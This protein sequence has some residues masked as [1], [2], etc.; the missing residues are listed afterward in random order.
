[1]M[2]WRNEY[3]RRY[4]GNELSHHKQCPSRVNL[5]A[6]PA[7][8][9][10][11]SA[12][13]GRTD[14]IVTQHVARGGTPPCSRGSPPTLSPA[15]RGCGCRSNVRCVLHPSPWSAGRRRVGFLCEHLLLHES[16]RNNLVRIPGRRFAQADGRRDSTP[17]VIAAH[18][19]VFAD[20]PTSRFR[21]SRGNFRN[22]YYDRLASYVLPLCFRGAIDFKRVYTEVTRAIG[23]QFIRHAL[24]DSTPIADL[25]SNTKRIPYCQIA[26]FIVNSLCLPM[27]SLNPFEAAVAERLACS[28]LTNVNRVKSPAGSLPD[29]C[30]W[31]RAG[32]CH[33]SPGFLGD[34]PV[35]PALP[36]QHRSIITSLHPH[37]H[38]RP[39]WFRLQNLKKHLY[40]KLQLHT[41]AKRRAVCRNAIR[42]SDSGN[43]LASGQ[44]QPIENLFQCTQWSIRHKDLGAMPLSGHFSPGKETLDDAGT[45]GGR[46][47]LR[48]SSA[49]CLCLPIGTKHTSHCSKTFRFANLLASRQ[50]NQHG[51]IRGMLQPIRH[52][53][54]LTEPRAAN[55]F[56]VYAMVNYKT[57]GRSGFNPRLGHSGFSHVGIVPDD[58][59]GS[60]VSPTFSFQRCSIL[61][62]ITLFGSQDISVKSRPNLLTHNTS[63]LEKH[64]QFNKHVWKLIPCT[65]NTSRARQQNG[66]TGQQNVGTP[67]VDRRLV[68]NSPAGSSAN[69]ELYAA[70]S[71][72]SDSRPVPRTS[73]SQSGKGHAHKTLVSPN[74]LILFPRKNVGLEDANRATAYPAEGARQGN[75]RFR[76]IASHSRVWNPKG[77]VVEKKG[78]PGSSPHEDR[79]HPPRANLP[80][81]Q[82]DEKDNPTGK[83][84]TCNPPSCRCATAAFFSSPPPFS[85][86]PGPDPGNSSH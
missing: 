40:C 36:L 76:L 18:S 15:D 59:V 67:F 81:Q 48:D 69:R 39:R 19:A 42:Q 38:S 58:A 8:A 1:M 61:T 63:E 13:N 47:C 20:G 14:R 22:R 26:H 25:Q 46:K 28:P 73:R 54:L 29:F 4:L 21:R 33:W 80:S 64:S 11:R 3:P 70:C 82:G 50:C 10:I 68:N 5:A 83:A 51:K 16:P 84:A 72:Q 60:P 35:P 74:T 41:P 17:K 86:S 79:L 43:L 52:K 2:E 77:V 7:P 32:R 27:Q 31:N 23:S 37:L 44:S 75:S 24:D 9:Y 65:A 49:R 66:A 30:K 34:L 12:V 57:S 62:S 53:A 45:A 6:V 56:V 71:S 85:T 55:Q 78:K